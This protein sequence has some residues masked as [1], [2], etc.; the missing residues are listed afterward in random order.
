MTSRAHWLYGQIASQE[1][2]PEDQAG[3]TSVT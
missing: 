1:E 2:A 3:T